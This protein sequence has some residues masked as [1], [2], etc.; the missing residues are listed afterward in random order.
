LLNREIVLS[1]GF[2]DPE[3]L[4]R[5]EPPYSLS[6]FVTQVL[7]LD[8]GTGSRIG[9]GDDSL[10]PN[11]LLGGLVGEMKSELELAAHGYWVGGLDEHPGVADV[12][13]PSGNRRRVCRVNDL[14]RLLDANGATTFFLDHD[15]ERYPMIVS[16]E[17]EAGR[18]TLR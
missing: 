9:P 5:H 1:G 3:V 16:F 10:A 17:R 7:E 2:V 13:D 8:S 4:G 11:R 12:V 15:K 14:E 6:V 18:A